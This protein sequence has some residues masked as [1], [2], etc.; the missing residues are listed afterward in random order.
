VAVG[1]T[2]IDSQFG[3]VRSRST[4]VRG[5]HDESVELLRCRVHL[6]HLAV[7]SLILLFDYV[8]KTAGGVVAIRSARM[9][10]PE[11][12]NVMHCG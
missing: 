4:I 10:A 1:S 8:V 12:F 7:H 11:E 6:D 3:R 9:S 5:S 2:E